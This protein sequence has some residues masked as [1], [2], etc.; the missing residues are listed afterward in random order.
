[1]RGQI[2]GASPGIKPS[3]THLY[4]RLPDD[5]ERPAGFFRVAGC[6]SFESRFEM[7][8]P[9]GSY[10]FHAY[11]EGSDGE[12]L[13]WPTVNLAADKPD[14]DLGVLTLTKRV[15]FGER[16]AKLKAAGSWG[17]LTQHY[18]RR[19]P[20]IFAQDSRGVPRPFQP[21][22]MPGK[23]VLIE[24]WGLDCAPCLGKS[25]PKLMEFREKYA[26]KLDRFEIVTVFIDVDEKIKTMTDLDKGLKPVVD[27]L[28]GGKNAA[29]PDP[30]RLGVSNLGELR[31]ARARDRDPDR[32]RREPRERR[33][34]S[35]G[36]DRFEAMKT[37]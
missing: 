33:S 34:R 37:S 3:W 9:P 35:P 16:I 13:P 36:G 28:W 26:S 22:D 30:A 15:G 18:G 7:S 29:V 19:P 21:W 25:L 14:V 8:L 24:F 23:W 6:G 32:P 27:H 20:R 5:P 10:V 12:V 2:E 4:T 11:G 17:D 1:M 31:P